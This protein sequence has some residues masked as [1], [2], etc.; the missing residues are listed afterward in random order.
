M[1]DP[2]ALKTHVSAHLRRELKPVV[3]KRDRILSIILPIHEI[4]LDS[5]PVIEKD[6][7]F[8]CRP[9]DSETILG[10]GDA[11]RITARGPDR[12]ESL[13]YKMQETHDR[14]QWIDPELT[15]FIPLSYLCFS[16][17]PNDQMTGPWNGLPNSGLFLPEITLRQSNNSCVA[18]F[19]VD[20]QNTQ[21]TESIHRR[22]MEL[23]SD[24][25]SAL[26]QPHNPPGCKT[27]LTRIAT[28]STQLKW[29]ELVAKAQSEISGNTMEKV[30]PARHQRIQAERRLDPRQLISIL[31]YLYPNSVLIATGIGKRVFVSATPEKLASL[32]DGT[33]TCDAIAGTIH[34][35]AV[36]ERDK[37]LG[38]DLLSDPKVR[39]EHQLVVDDITASLDPL[40]SSIDY[41]KHPS[42]LRLRNLQHLITEI[43]GR[44]KP[45]IN[46]LQA[47]AKLHPTAAVNGSPGLK[48][49]EWLDQNE[50][51]NRGWYAGAAGWI[52][53][54]GEG[55][56]AVLLRC[57]LLD[58]DQADLFAGAGITAGSD[59][60]AEYAETELKFG[61]ILEAL[62]NA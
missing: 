14:W 3:G 56:L 62:E 29:R 59:A 15:G 33:L 12:L 34:R 38:R 9:S 1:L 51:F 4:R 11:M 19:C 22:W 2:Q 48:A 36:E 10:L 46:L 5:L 39:H 23:F 57:A 25:L 54:R 52:D 60:D 30:V 37:A 18:S 24:L 7:Y 42:L 43:K 17:N 45:D 28:S 32:H 41:R 53:C 20:L 26:D 44:L 40:C 61:A 49:R 13:N 55:D 47:A 6:W 16:F 58:R 35:S 50:D 21:D 8:W 27:V 31:N